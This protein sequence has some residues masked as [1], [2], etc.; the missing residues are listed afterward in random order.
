M[1]VSDGACD[2]F[3]YRVSG[4]PTLQLHLSTVMY[5]SLT[6]SLTHSL[7]RSLAHSRYKKQNPVYLF[8]AD[9]V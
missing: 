1:T 9:S 2:A 6:R 4:N 7:T 8:G 3:Y 5:H